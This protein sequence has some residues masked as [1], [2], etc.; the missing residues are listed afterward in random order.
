MLEHGIEMRVAEL[1]EGKTVV[2]FAE[3]P[4]VPWTAVWSFHLMPRGADRCQFLI[5]SRLGL[6]HPGE[7]MLAELFG[8]PRAM[9]TR[10]ILLGIKR[11]GESPR[12]AEAAAAAS[13]EVHHVG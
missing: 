5:R 6:R 2:L 11:R 10:G 9:L 3:P 1:V 7:V 4:G 8:P 12:Q 13:A